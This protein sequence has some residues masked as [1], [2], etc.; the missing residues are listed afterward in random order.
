M[1]PNILDVFH[2]SMS[3]NELGFIVDILL[4]YCVINYTLKML[5]WFCLQEHDIKDIIKL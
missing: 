4:K 5:L 3:H 1:D 2:F